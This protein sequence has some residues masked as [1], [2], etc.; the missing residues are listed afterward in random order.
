M[1]IRECAI[2]TPYFSINA[3][4]GSNRAVPWLVDLANANGSST[5]VRPGTTVVCRN[6]TDGL[7]LLGISIMIAER[8]R[9]SASLEDL[10]MQID[11]A[12]R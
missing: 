8:H 5:S 1:R 3:L 6:M 4:A 12:D 10:L 9:L 11:D 7:C 2:K